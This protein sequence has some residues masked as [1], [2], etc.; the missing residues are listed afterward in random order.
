MD[1]DPVVYQLIYTS[2][3]TPALDDFAL[4]EIAQSSS[5]NN[6]LLGLTGLLLFNGRSI[7]QL[8]EG[9]E[10]SVYSLYGKVKRDKRQTH[11]QVLKA[12]I[13]QKR[14]CLD[15]FMGYKNITDHPGGEAL[16]NLNQKKFSTV[17]PFPSPHDLEA[18]MPSYQNVSGF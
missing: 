1:G 9:D 11:C 10:M 6:Q 4:R 5:F 3:A 18:L 16:F 7:L 12:G 8:I 15:T 13:G 17:L 14:E 2:I